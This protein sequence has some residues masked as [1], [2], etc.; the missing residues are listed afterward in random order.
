MENFGIC[1]G[2][3][4]NIETDTNRLRLFSDVKVKRH[5]WLRLDANP[6]LDS[7]Y[8]LNR[9]NCLERKESGVQTKLSF[10]SYSRPQWGL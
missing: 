3:G 4:M 8:F 5:P 10:F 6:F 7:D 2:C 1:R 9:M